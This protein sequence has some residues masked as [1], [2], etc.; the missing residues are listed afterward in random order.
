MDWTMPL[1]ILE[2]WNNWFGYPLLTTTWFIRLSCPHIVNDELASSDHIWDSRSLDV[3]VFIATVRSIPSLLTTLIRSICVHSP[4]PAALSLIIGLGTCGLLAL[5]YSHHQLLLL[6]QSSQIK[7]VDILSTHSSI[8]L[9]SWTIS[10]PYL[11]FS[12]SQLALNLTK[13]T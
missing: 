11:I 8:Y 10:S 12:S 4:R 9:N 3:H 2:I 13:L 7:S 6:C 1:D 5:F